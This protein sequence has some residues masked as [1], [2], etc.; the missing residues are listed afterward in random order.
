MKNT[1]IVNC[2]VTDTKNAAVSWKTV[3]EITAPEQKKKKRRKKKRK[4]NENSLRD[5]WDKTEC[6]NNFIL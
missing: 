1:D 4:R 5:L 6:T 2:K 3:V